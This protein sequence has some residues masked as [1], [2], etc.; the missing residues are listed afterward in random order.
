MSFLSGGSSSKRDVSDEQQALHRRILAAVLKGP[1]NRCCADCGTRNPTWSSVNLGVFVC[2]TC[3][4]IHRSLG[5]HISQVRSCNLDTWLPKQVEFVRAMGNARA[6]AF[7]EAR[8]PG[9]FRRPPGGNPNPE[10]AAFIRAK[11][12]DRRYAASDAAPPDINNYTDHPYAGAAAPAAAAAAVGASGSGGQQPQ[13]AGAGSATPPLPAGAGGS[14]AAARRPPQQ[15]ADLLSLSPAAAR[16]STGSLSASPALAAASATDPFDLLAGS[17]SNSPAPPGAAAQPLHLLDHDDWSDFHSAPP[18]AAAGGGSSSSGAGAAA[19][20]ADPFAASIT[21]AA[22]A[23]SPPAAAALAAGP[24]SFALPAALAASA[25]GT[26]AA[27][28]AAGRA[29]VAPTAA[30][31]APAPADPFAHLGGHDLISSISSMAVSSSSPAT[32]AAGG[33]PPPPRNSGSGSAAG[34]ASKKST[35]EDIM[36]LYD[37]PQQPLAQPVHQPQH[38][39]AHHRHHHHPHAH[40]PAAGD[41]M[42]HLAGQG[43]AAAA[44]GTFWHHP[45]SAMLPVSPTGQLAQQQ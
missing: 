45:L 27:P 38:H 29:P 39:H 40:V 32:T 6:N 23:A 21:G 36:A 11:Y 9:G 37:A 44:P 10:L 17:T 8:L 33:A 20:A 2:L 42:P 14:T 7:W 35:V 28:T 34:D 4:G 19:P 18:A 41:V 25:V 22:A 16:G 1:D 26:S 24:D 30:A 3:S 13:Q 31:A 12:V 15:Q 5:V 43:G